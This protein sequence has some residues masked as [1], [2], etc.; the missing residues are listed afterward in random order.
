MTSS[1]LATQGHRRTTRDLVLYLGV[2]FATTLAHSPLTSLPFEAG[3][4]TEG[5]GL[6]P[7]TVGFLATLELSAYALT[8]FA[9][10]PFM[11]RSA[12]RRAAL[13]G[14]L[15]A[16]A[17]T[18]LA[19]STRDLAVF[20]FSRI[21]AGIGFGTVFSCANAA[22]ARA[23]IPERAYSIGMGVS[24]V[25]FTVLPIVLA[26]S[27]HLHR[28]AHI[29][30]L[31]QSGVFLAIAALTIVLTPA[32]LLLPNTPPGLPSVQRFDGTSAQHSASAAASSLVIM[33]CFSVA[34]FSLYTFLELRGRA[35]GMEAS[36]IG[37]LLAATIGI[38]M[39]GTFASTWLGRRY[40]RILPLVIGLALQGL[41]CYAVAASAAP[42]ELW[43]ASSLYFVFWYFIYPY[44]MGL[45]ASIDPA[46]R[47]PTALGGAYL[48]G[49]SIAASLGGVLLQKG[50]FV[51]AGVAGCGMCLVAALIA[52]CI[53][54]VRTHV[55]LAR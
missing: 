8:N 15:L 48:V 9:I 30:L 45:G 47:L 35:L 23:V 19:A 18:I 43:V 14:A 29:V 37:T 27:M 25:F 42:L 11:G 38:G 32:L 36:Q 49:S 13:M 51:V 22:G 44:I 2:A 7:S 6:T 3:A 17:A 33:L 26:R 1:T 41:S 20:G 12:P 10:S 55:A 16:L 53:G 24:I 34:V 54:R 31:P 39:L 5:L 52:L 40:G 21:L 50:G 4:V 28:V 46:G